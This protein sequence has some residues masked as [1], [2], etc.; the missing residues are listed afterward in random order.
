VLRSALLK[1]SG[2]GW[3]AERLPHSALGRRVSARFIPGETIDDAVAAARGLSGQG[4]H[5]VL[6]HLGEEVH[7]SEAADSA[8]AAYEAALGA[9]AAA[10][11]EVQVSVKPTHLGLALDEGHAIARTDRLLEAAASLN[12]F[13]WIDMEGSA[14]TEATVR[15]YERLRAAHPNAGLCL[16]A[17]LHRTPADIERLLPLGPAIR[18]VKGAYSEPP[19][20]AL[21]RKA[22]VDEA[23]FELARRL[24]AARA[25]GASVALASHDVR[26]I[27]RIG[28]DCEVQMLYGIRPDE[29]RRLAAAGR[30]VRVLISY[31]SE[32]F[33]WYM[34]RLA[35]RPANLL[36]AI[37]ATISRKH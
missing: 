24:I 29:Q 25:D 30:P 1:I 8:C 27:E 7:S 12:G 37:R 20:I 19:T 16:Q 34:R 10:K 28:G 23:Y 14:Y 17:Y 21:T 15:M 35:E 6:S 22:D 36:F 13:V 11:L 33:A 26:L 31:G 9:L 32:W 18:L 4:L 3:L 2:N 5:T